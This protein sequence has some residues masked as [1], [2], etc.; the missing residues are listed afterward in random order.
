MNGPPDNPGSGLLSALL[1]G[2]CVYWMSRHIS[3]VNEFI[4]TVLLLV[5]LTTAILNLCAA[6]RRA[7]H[8]ARHGRGALYWL[9]RLAH[10]WALSRSL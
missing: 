5:S 2:S 6:V 4:W 8:G 9:R 3:A 7:R 1:C 10:L